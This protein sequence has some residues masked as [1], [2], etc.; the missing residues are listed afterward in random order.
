[1]DLNDRRLSVVG[2]GDKPSFVPVAPPLVPI[3]EDY[4]A[5]VRPEVASSAFFFVNPSTH[6]GHP[7]EGRFGPTCVC[8]LVSRAGTGAGVRGRRFPGP[9]A[10]L[11]RHYPLRAGLDMHFVQRLL[12]H[13]A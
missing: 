8:R 10:P 6:R 7:Y 11:Q 13:L 3:L 2:E 4:L 12:G 5:T 9:L 1:V